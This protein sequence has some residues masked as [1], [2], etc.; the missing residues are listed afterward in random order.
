M[1]FKRLYDFLRELERNNSKQWMDN[2]RKR[3]HTVRNDFIAWL[4]ELDTTLGALDDNYYATP[5]KKGI[6]ASITI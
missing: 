3:Y 4:D 6:R 2:N 1:N 5:G